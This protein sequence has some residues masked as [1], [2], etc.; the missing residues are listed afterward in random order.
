M[1]RL[2]GVL[3]LLVPLSFAFGEGKNT[4]VEGDPKIT[5]RCNRLDQ[6]SRCPTNVVDFNPEQCTGG[7]VR[8]GRPGHIYRPP[9]GGDWPGEDTSATSDKEAVDQLCP[10]ASAAKGP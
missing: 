3:T 7:A 8:D 6:Y 9:V 4:K 5:L 2:L 1:K 10:H